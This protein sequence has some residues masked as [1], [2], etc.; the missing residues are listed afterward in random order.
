LFE[1]PRELGWVYGRDFVVEDRAYGDE[2]ERVPDLAAELIRT[3]VDIFVVSGAA[4]PV[5]VQ[6]VTKTIPIVAWGAGDLVAAGAATSVARPG[7]NI[8]GIQTLQPELTPK[9]LSLLK[10]AIPGLSRAGILFRRAPTSKVLSSDDPVLRE[11]EVAGKALGIALQIVTVRSADELGRAFAA[12]SAQRAQAVII[13]RDQ[14]MGC[15]SSNRRS[16]S[17]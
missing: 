13:V 5:R 2:I 17:W 11:V 9:Q 8:T 16:S 15:P 3:G 14:F 4:D 7:G 10:E 1:R 6:R 12:F